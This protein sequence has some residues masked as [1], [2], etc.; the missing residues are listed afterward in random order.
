[1]PE[2]PR[3]WVRDLQNLGAT[4]HFQ[5]NEQRAESMNPTT[6]Q[7][8]AGERIPGTVYCVEE[9]IGS[10]GM[11]SV[12]RVEHVE[13]G[14]K[15]VL[16]ALHGHL[17]S[18]GDLV[19][20]LR[21]EWRALGKLE[22]PNIVQVTDAGQTSAGLPF[23]VMENLRGQTLGK[24]LA[25]RGRLPVKLSCEIISGVL[26]GLHA[27]H[28]TGAVHRDIKPPNIFVE[29]GGRAKLLDF[30]IAKLRDQAAKVVTAGGVSIGTPRY[31]A[32][33]QAA[34]TTV[35][36]RADIYATALVLYEM[37]AGRG[38][39][40]DIR[41]PNE[42]VLAHISR[43]PDRADFIAPDVPPEIADLIQRWLSKMPSSRPF[44]AE[45]AQR[46]LESIARS[47]ALDP[48]STLDDVTLGGAYDAATWGAE[49]DSAKSLHPAPASAR[50]NEA[51]EFA[52]APNSTKTLP[53]DERVVDGIKRASDAVGP[54][55]T[56]GWGT[57]K[58]DLLGDTALPPESAREG[59][60]SRRRSRSTT[61]PPISSFAASRMAGTSRHRANL[62]WI[63]ATATISF[64][65]AYGILQLVGGGSTQQ[66]EESSEIS[67]EGESPSA[68]RPRSEIASRSIPPAVEEAE[69]LEESKG[70]SPET[71]EPD[72]AD[73]QSATGTVRAADLSKPSTETPR[74]APIHP[75]PQP[76]PG[77]A[78][79]P[80]PVPPRPKKSPTPAV[81]LPDSGL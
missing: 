34:G 44:S 54:A 20:R 40:Q 26:A 41:D 76:A 15:F 81:Q 79:R 8:R 49:S 80:Q 19:A 78:P 21:N 59:L 69:S 72:P 13:L 30:G 77:M 62:R 56:L 68:A 5:A 33:E 18:R 75:P 48:P 27:A 67:L 1:M 42:L 46:E 7:F 10:G 32:P 25:E 37:L 24:L 45:I 61:P 74:I 71:Q 3:N 6:N 57:S 16:K 39:F 4:R 60:G 53:I 2:K 23:Y 28:A 36:G 65:A 43:E 47:L 51:T 64:A 70:P 22:H 52:R 50:H 14:R 29:E 12:Y 63:A 73:A 9:L 11:G 55:G 38:P 35:D 58:E 31:M 66:P 17:S